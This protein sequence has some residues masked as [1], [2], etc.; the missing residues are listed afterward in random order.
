L[1]RVLSLPSLHRVHDVELAAVVDGEVEPQAGAPGGLVFGAGDQAL[2]RWAEAAGVANDA[3]LHAL[4]FEFAHLALQVAAQQGHEAGD[5]FGRAAPVFGAE[6]EDGERLDV[7]DRAGT[8]KGTNAFRAGFVT[9]DGRQLALLCPT[10]VAV[11]DDGQVFEC[12]DGATSV[13]VELADFT[14][15]LPRT[16]GHLCGPVTA[17]WR[18]LRAGVC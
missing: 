18:W 3:Q 2:H 12:V 5:F 11:H 8:H 14:G 15:D 17:R 6:G 9:E 4:G 1:F 10:S 7:A 16:S 13:E